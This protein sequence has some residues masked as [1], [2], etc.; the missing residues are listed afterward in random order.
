M[1]SHDW[2]RARGLFF[3]DYNGM[4]LLVR[5]PVEVVAA[6]MAEG[7]DLW[8]RDVLGREVVLQRDSV[9]VFRLKGHEWATVVTRHFARVPWGSKGHEWEKSLS[10]RVGAPIIVYGIS[11][12][13]GSIGYT[14]IEGG[15]VVEDFF[16]ED[17]GSGPASETSW[18]TSVRRQV[19]LAEIE[20]TYDFVGRF[21]VAQD[22]C[23][24]G[25]VFD[26]F[27]D[28]HPPEN[29]KPGTVENPGLRMG[30]LGKGRRVIPEIERLDY[31]NL[32]P[33]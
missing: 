23:D 31:L 15:E 12:T 25:I 5:A 11:D 6:A 29:G 18:F 4:I 21:F 30:V 26:Y 9:F 33:S 24:P 13:C 14:L 19:R 10:R 17:Q 16:A 7:A 22:A 27:F 3:F 8:R 1:E 32:K 28:H 20:N 2:E